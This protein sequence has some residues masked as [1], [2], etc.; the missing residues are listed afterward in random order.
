VEI[1]RNNQELEQV[2]SNY[3]LNNPGHTIGFVHTMGALHDGHMSL[4][5]QANAEV[6]FVISSVFVNPAQFNETADLDKYPRTESVD[7]EL[8][9]SNNCDLVYIPTVENIYP[10]NKSNYS[11]NLKGL[12]KVM[13]GKYRDSHFDGVCMVV[14]RLFDLVKTNYAFFGKKDFQQVAIVSHMVKERGLSVEV[15][16]C[17]IMREDSGLAMSSRNMLMSNYEREQATIISESL[18]SG[19]KVYQGGF[20]I[21]RVIE[22][23]LSIFYRGSLELEYL[24]IID[25][26][27]LQKVTEINNNCTVCVAAYCGSVRL[28]DNFQFSR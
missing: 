5:R 7:I 19:V 23:M 11:I 28:I 3:K 24:E 9:E 21:D 22:T 10:N 4:I 16:S 1:A 20:K 8:L 15:V 27:T 18:R 26:T 2:L 6:N 12:D 17:P 25:N 14:E 13:E